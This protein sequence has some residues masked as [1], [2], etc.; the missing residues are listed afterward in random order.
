MPARAA[1][2]TAA[3]A[4]AEHLPPLVADLVAEHHH[5]VTQRRGAYQKPNAHKGIEPETAISGW[6]ACVT[7][8][9]TPIRAMTSA[10]N[11]NDGSHIK[12][13]GSRV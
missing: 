6:T 5:A 4:P 10:S 7:A 8:D 11:Q 3:G 1:H 9:E 13:R 12:S 2:Q